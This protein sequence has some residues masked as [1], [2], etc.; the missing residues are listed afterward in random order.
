MLEHTQGGVRLRSRTVLVE[1]KMPDP[2]LTMA[3]LDILVS[4]ICV[5]LTFPAMY[6]TYVQ[7]IGLFG[8]NTDLVL[9]IA[10]SIF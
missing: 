4:T 1:D 10:I 9:K 2:L 7:D 6:D 5:Y 3:D 8:E